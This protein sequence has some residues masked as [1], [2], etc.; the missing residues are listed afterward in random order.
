MAVLVSNSDVLNFL[1]IGNDD[2]SAQVATDLATS[3]ETLLIKQ[4]G[5]EWRPFQA[6]TAGRI[7]RQDGTGHGT[8]YLDYPIAALTSVTV[9]STNP[10]TLLVND[11]SKL[12]WSVGS[13]RLRRADGGIFGA[14]GMGATV[15]VTYDTADDLPAD[16][17][18]AVLRRVARIWRQRGAE[19]VRS[20]RE[21]GW[22][23]D[24]ALDVEGD[25][26]WQKVIQNYRV[27]VLGE[28]GL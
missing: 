21:G 19:D 18:L 27:P 8:L 9:G 15:T 1:G 3:V 11:P 14:W 17:G 2:P 22:S 13:T 20:E 4:C 23:A 16:A 28:R 26:E 12:L 5:R 25:P 7:E 10:E 24:A 6:A